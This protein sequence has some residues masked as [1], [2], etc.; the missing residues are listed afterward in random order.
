MKDSNL[1][2]T[3]YY[4]DEP[5][6]TLVAVKLVFEILFYLIVVLLLLVMVLGARIY[7]VVGWSMQPTID[8]MSI[9]FVVGDTDDVYEVDDI[10]TFEMGGAVNTH[11][12]IEVV[13]NVENDASS[14][15]LYYHTKG[16]NPNIQTLI[17]A[18]TGEEIEEQI[19]PSR[20]I[21]KVLTIGN[22]VATIPGV[23]DFILFC[24][25]YIVAVIL[26]FV[27]GYMVIFSLPNATKYRQYYPN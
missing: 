12:I 14:G 26:C 23:G 22:I 19:V 25:N 24:Q 16:D 1:V 4:Y 20:V 6:P 5:N 8:Y 7:V 17:D 21:G 9:V 2:Y 13:Y 15:V 27:G 3:K 18:G 11:R 10:I